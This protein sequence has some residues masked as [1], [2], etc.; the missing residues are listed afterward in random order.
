MFGGGDDDLFDFVPDIDGDGDHDLLDFLIMDDILQEEERETEGDGDFDPDED[1]E[2]FDEDDENDENDENDE[3]DDDKSDEED[4]DDEESDEDSLEVLTADSPS[5]SAETDVVKSEQS[6]QDSLNKK[7]IEQRRANA[8]ANLNEQKRGTFYGSHEELVRSN[9]VAF[10]KCEAAK[11]LVIGG[12]YFLYTA[13][14]SDHY[15]L[16]FVVPAQFDTEKMT[17][18]TLL[19]DLVEDD[20]DYAM[21]I[22]DWCLD[23][24]Q[25][26]LDYAE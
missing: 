25:P 16:P 5:I 19:V 10:N 14:V 13:A 21:E 24:F 1:E 4:F 22:W 26:Y 23:T 18:E 15:E 7:Y 12:G 17:F 6:V 11:Y 20:P 9:F 3:F 8:L 2:D